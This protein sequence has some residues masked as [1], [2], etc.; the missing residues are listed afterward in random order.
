MTTREGSGVTAGSTVS[1]YVIPLPRCSRIVTPIPPASRWSS[2]QPKAKATSSPLRGLRTQGNPRE[3]GRGNSP[4]RTR[5]PVS[6]FGIR[7]G[8][9]HLARALGEEET[10]TGCIS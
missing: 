2:C 6:F 9:R 5:V 1:R 3:G 4:G 7:E 8:I 10:G